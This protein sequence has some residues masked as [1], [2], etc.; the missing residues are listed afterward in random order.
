MNLLDRAIAWISPQR[1]MQR[2][3]A[4]GY[5]ADPDLVRKEAIQRMA[6]IRRS[7]DAGKTDRS[8]WAWRA[9]Q[10]SGESPDVHEIQ[11]ARWRAW[12]LYRN[13]PY[14]RRAVRSIVNKVLGCGLDPQSLATK[15]SGEA[16]DRFRELARLLW[17]T[18]TPKS[19]ARGLP[20]RGGLNWEQQ[21]QQALV[22]WIVSGEVLIRR[23]TLPE[24]IC[25]RENRR[26]DFAVEL[27]SCERLVEY[28]T[29]PGGA[30]P[31]PIPAGHY[32][33]RGI[34]FD[35]ED[36]RVAYHIWDHH[37]NDP[38]PTAWQRTSKRLPAE[39]IL[40][41]YAPD[42]PDQ[43]RGV[44]QFTT[45][46]LQLR[47]VGDY[48]ENEMEASLVSSC[49]AMGVTTDG[50]VRPGLLTPT[51][52]RGTDADGNQL[53][54]MQP[55]MIVPLQPGEKIEGF[56]PSRPTSGAENF[57]THMLRGVAVGFAGLK[58]STLTG[59]YRGASFSAEKAADNDAWADIE[60]V[61]EW[62]A[63]TLCQPV[64]E[65]LLDAG[66]F[67]GWFDGTDVPLSAE[68]YQQHRERLVA[69]AWNGPT[70]KSINPAVDVKA[71]TMRI[72]AGLSN[73]EIE[74]AALGYTTDEI[75]EGQKRY[76]Q[77]KKESGLADMEL[78][79]AKAKAESHGPPPLP[80]QGGKKPP[81]PSSNG[82]P[83]GNIGQNKKRG[84]GRGARARNCGTGAG[85]FQPGNK[86]GQLRDALSPEVNAS[87]DAW[88]AKAGEVVEET[89]LFALTDAINHQLDADFEAQSQDDAAFHDMLLDREESAYS[90]GTVVESNGRKVVRFANDDH[91]A[92]YL[93]AKQTLDEWEEVPNREPIE[94]D[95]EDLSI[96]LPGPD[97]EETRYRLKPIT[98]EQIYVDEGNADIDAFKEQYRKPPQPNEAS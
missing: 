44:T 29:A 95:T 17:L 59:D 79:D 7:Y 19:D 76:L 32:L 64:Y 71:A 12:D 45:N 74:A 69:A 49:V 27:I 70:P 85:G 98:D 61:Q 37:P 82:G 94:V 75:V 87:I 38:R 66:V 67:D 23:R 1:A 5:L 53:A 55:G 40:H 11:Q 97:D 34:E 72:E 47:D 28:T 4:R 52:G 57:L 20:G 50:A 58:A 10:Q 90:K 62:F 54:R 81:G 43:Q 83:E 14:A 30:S 26:L 77:L 89:E 65:W 24:R 63:S 88:N 93:D 9:Q 80:S 60:Q 51:G 15:P 46:L 48:Q 84:E 42:R 36:R 21:A 91:K 22:E 35:G 96:E 41:V 18:F 16:D 33:W 86:C 25:K 78:A 39:E 68:S 8:T 92:A 73:H 2:E 13:N 56:N 31:I 3:I 6:A